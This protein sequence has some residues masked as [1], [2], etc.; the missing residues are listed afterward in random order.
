MTRSTTADPPRQDTGPTIVMVGCDPHAPGGI[1][2]VIRLLLRGPLAERW[3]LEAMP[4]WVSGSRTRRVAVYLQTLGRL[5]VRARR[6][7]LQAVHLHLAARGSFWRK[8]VISR[9]LHGSGVTVMVHIHDGT[10]PQWHAASPAWLQRL[11]RRLLE[12]SDAV[13]ALS[14]AWVDQLRPLAPS[15]R[16]RVVRNPVETQAARAHA[17]P[18]SSSA[19]ARQLL[20]LGRLRLDKGLDD[21]LVAARSLQAAHPHWHWMLA[22]DGDLDAVRRHIV[23][24]GLA[25]SVTLTGWLDEQGKQ[26]ALAT[27]DVLVLP[28]HAEGQPLAVLEAMACGLPV[29]ATQVG[30]I[31]ELLACGAGRVVRVG[32]TQGLAQ[33]LH[34]V[35]DDL[36]AARSMGRLGRLY[37]EQHHAAQRVAA[38]VEA[39]YRELGL[40]PRC[41][42]AALPPQ[43]AT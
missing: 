42:P 40:E 33:A 15:A 25:P 13:I 18:L 26:H 23:E 35:L 9:L 31:P 19:K 14:P 2:T 34:E 16:W 12:D 11:F 3:P 32:D 7:R 29:V 37:A 21:L 28:S 27:A 1:S 5:W 30:D 8:W 22:G 43:L 39:V 4:T 10:L 36:E 38:Q 41:T 6:G 24:I 20:F 17:T